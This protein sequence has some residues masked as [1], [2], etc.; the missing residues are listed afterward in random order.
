LARR[1]G[2]PKRKGNEGREK[3]SLALSP[4]LSPGE[5]SSFS[6]P[7]YEE[8][9]DGYDDIE[10]DPRRAKKKL[11]VVLQLWHVEETGIVIVGSLKD[12]TFVEP[13]SPLQCSQIAWKES[14]VTGGRKED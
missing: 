5:F 12:K 3:R 6:S 4:P 7:L 10:L 13:L 1:D 14:I 2:G 11:D 8:S 9:R